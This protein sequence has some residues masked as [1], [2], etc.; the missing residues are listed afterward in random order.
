MPQEY[1]TDL[2]YCVQVVNT[3][4]GGIA[5]SQHYK[6]DAF[7]VD[8]ALGS[9]AMP[10]FAELA[11]IYA[12]FRT[13]RMSYKFDFAN[14]EA[15]PVTVFAGFSNS[16]IASGSLTETYMGNPLFKNKQIGPLTGA[17]TA[18]LTGSKT[19]VEIAGTRQPLYDDLYTGSTGS[20]TLAT[21]GTCHVYAAVLSPVVMTAAGVV[22]NAV[23]TLKVQFYRQNVFSA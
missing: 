11:A 13:L 20:S 18:R 17:G 19:I 15:F 23:V 9:T 5:A 22:I 3:A 14:Q 7:D 21:T 2:K 1:V 16:S 4:V 6:S 12:R 10:G 8:A